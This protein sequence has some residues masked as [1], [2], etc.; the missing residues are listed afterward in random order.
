MSDQADPSLEFDPEPTIGSANCLTC[1]ARQNKDNTLR[2]RSVSVNKA[3]STSDPTAAYF[4]PEAKPSSIRRGNV[5][6]IW[7]PNDMVMHRSTVI[8]MLDNGRSWQG[9]KIEKMENVPSDMDNMEHYWARVHV[10]MS[11]AVCHKINYDAD[12]PEL[13]ELTLYPDQGQTLA[14][15]CMVDL[16]RSYDIGREDEYEVIYCGKLDGKSFEYARKKHLEL[17]GAG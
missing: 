1:S 2:A 11:S 13:H 16:E 8:I 10:H 6:R 14:S 17:Y 9:C 15:E 3:D 7:K 5:Y 4:K 12:Q